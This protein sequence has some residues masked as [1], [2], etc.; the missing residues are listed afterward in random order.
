MPNPVRTN[1]LHFL[2]FASI[3]F[4]PSL[5][6]ATVVR[7]Q[8]L[9]TDYTD[10]TTVVGQ[11]GGTGFTG[12]W[13]ESGGLSSAVNFY[14]RA[15][16][17]SYSNLSTSGGQLE[18]FREITSTAPANTKSASRDFSFMPLTISGSSQMYIGFLFEV[19][20]G[21]NFKWAYNDES[22]RISDF[23]VTTG[24]DASFVGGGTSGSTLNLGTVQA[25]TNMLLLRVSDATSGSPNNPFYD[26]IE[27]W[28]NPDLTNLGTADDVGFGIISKFGGGDTDEQPGSYNLSGSLDAGESFGFDEFFVTDDLNAVLVPEPSSAVLLFLSSL[29]LIRRRR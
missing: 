5:H 24:G 6:A 4:L 21:A 28:L 8:F 22:N 17:L 10:D 3:S 7:E 18:H 25:G 19:D 27:A 14:P 12:T 1:Y 2:A 13:S 26:E 16:G 20:S 11:S 23:S 29:A 15:S 9:A